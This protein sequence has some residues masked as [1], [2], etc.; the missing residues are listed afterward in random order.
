MRY[1]HIIRAVT[2]TPWAIRADRLAAILDL[3]AY[4]AAGHRFTPEEI[5]ARIG[6]APVRRQAVAAGSVA[7][8][9]L[10][11][12]MVPKGGMLTEMSGATSTEQFG[13]AIAAAAADQS[14]DAILIDIDSPGGMTDLVPETAAVI[15]AARE[16]KPVVAIA[17][18]DAASA[19]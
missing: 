18:T 7:V 6:A 12:V 10:A 9:P 4:R 11:G 17:N 13:A 2:D 1:E 15:R 5:E 14:V 16:Q 8:I 3:V 19:A